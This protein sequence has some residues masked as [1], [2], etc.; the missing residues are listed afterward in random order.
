MPGGQV[1]L[2]DGP[3]GVMSHGVR[4]GLKSTPE[5]TYEPVFVVYRL[6][7]LKRERP[8]QQHGA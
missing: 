5:V 7:A 4:I 6:C 2:V 8:A 3:I 1:V